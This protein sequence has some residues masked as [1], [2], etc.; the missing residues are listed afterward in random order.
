MAMYYIPLEGG[1]RV[2]SRTLNE[3]NKTAAVVLLRVFMSSKGN[4][5]KKLPDYHPSEGLPIY[6]SRTGKTA[7]HWVKLHNGKD[8]KGG[9]DTVSYSKNYGISA[10]GPYKFPE[11]W[12]SEVKWDLKR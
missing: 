1:Y 5:H 11:S 3:A 6:N 12:I 7:T 9:Y 2:Y 8:I 10:K 4:V